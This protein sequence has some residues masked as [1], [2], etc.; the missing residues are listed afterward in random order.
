MDPKDNTQM[1]LPPE[2]AQVEE[3]S[4]EVEDFDLSD[5]P[6]DELAVFNAIAL[7]EM[8]DKAKDLKLAMAEA[9]VKLESRNVV[10][11]FVRHMTYILFRR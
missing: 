5:V 10:Q 3:V 2:I 7:I 1:K 8:G 6:R 4:S 9:K 11:D